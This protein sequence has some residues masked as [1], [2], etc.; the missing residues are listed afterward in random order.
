[1]EKIDWFALAQQVGSLQGDC[2][3]GSWVMGRRAIELLLGEEAIRSSVDYYIAGHRG[4]EL[5]CSVL[6]YIK[7]FS[8]MERCLEV[9]RSD[10]DA[11]SRHMAIGLLQIIADARA[12]EWVPE[13][14]RDE[15]PAIQMWGSCV[16]DQVLWSNLADPD[17]CKD[18]LEAMEKHPNVDVQSRAAFIRSFLAV[19]QTQE[20][21]DNSA[22][23]DDLQRA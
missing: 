14:L 17:D 5:A 16:V 11:W 15:D 19:R 3:V 1:M 10:A 6:S 8:A 7:P 9:V 4:S 2:E 20:E 23:D 13:F 22:D 18:L 21:T 12:L